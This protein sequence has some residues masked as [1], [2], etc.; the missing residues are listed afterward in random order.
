LIFDVATFAVAFAIALVLYPTAIRT[1]QRLKAGQV[2]Q[3]ELPESH[4][5]KAG[6]PTGG[7]I[8]FAVL[9]IVGGLLAALAG[10]AGAWPAVSGLVAG[11][12][13]GFAD[14]LSKLR[15]GSLGIPARLKL[16]I[17][18]LLALPVAYFA[19]SASAPPCAAPPSLICAGPHQYLLPF[20]PWLLFP[21]A[22]IAIVATANAVNITDGMDGLAGGLSVIAIAAV[23][24]LLP[25]APAGEKAV[26]MSLAGALV[27][28][29][30][31]NR[32]PARVF[33]GDTGSLAI[34]FALAAMAIQQGWLVLLPLVALVFVLETLSVIIQVAYFKA[35]GG[36]RVFK[37]APIHYTFHHQGWSENRIALTFW[38]AGLVSALAAAGVVRLIIR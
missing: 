5:K 37:M 16:P 20:E 14:D 10:H 9:G 29:L 21:L 19:I 27:A 38:G 3:S 4:Q 17:Q 8:L 28:F 23:V 7:G 26:A 18:V 6:T 22:V 2:I 32:Y 30:V 11:G 25:G 36:R 15:V 35:S 1:L 34:G 13:I 33:M 24:L 31:F 12:L